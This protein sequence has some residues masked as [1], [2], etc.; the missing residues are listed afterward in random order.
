M[1][2]TSSGSF[3]PIRK[4]PKCDNV[5]FTRRLL[6]DC[7]L[8]QC[9]SVF[10]LLYFVLVIWSWDCMM[11]NWTLEKCSLLLLPLFTYRLYMF[12][13]SIPDHLSAY[14]RK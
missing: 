3:N 7:L 10:H 1:C 5:P 8:L 12:D 14:I 11:S 9:E 6:D 13:V 4:G 2:F